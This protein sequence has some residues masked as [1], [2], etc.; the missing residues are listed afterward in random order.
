MSNYS[1]G[2]RAE[3]VAAE[4]L[5]KQGYTIVELNWRH[6]RAEID[7]IA[8]K[9]PR[10]R[11]PGPLVFFEV[12]HRKTD[13]QGRGLDYITPKK[14]EQMRF[15]AELYVSLQCYNGKYT[16]GGIELS[17]SDYHITQVLDTIMA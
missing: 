10:F 15:A 13:N 12:K 8:Q 3:Q 5:E 4:Y 11:R 9:R 14:L 6:A 2:H 17:G 1:S 7:I 16:L